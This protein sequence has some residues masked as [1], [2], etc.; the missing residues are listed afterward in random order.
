MKGIGEK[1]AIELITTYGD[2]DAIL[3][4]VE[5]ITKKRPREALLAHRDDALLSRT[6]VT[7]HC[8]APV[9]LD[10]DALAFH[11]PDVARLRQVYLDLEFASLARALGEPDAPATA[12]AE[13]DALAVE[14]TAMA[15]D[16]PR[17]SFDI[18][19][20]P[21]ANL[22]LHYTT[23]TTR[24]QLAAC[25]ARCRAV[26]SIAFDTETVLE[27]GAPGPVN[28]QRS[29]LVSISIAT[30]PGEAWYLP[31]AHVVVGAA[32]GDLLDGGELSVPRPAEG[33]L[34][35]LTGPEC[36]DFRALLEDA[37]VKKCAQNA[38]Y[39]LLVLRRA[40]VELRGLDFDPMLASYV[41][42]PGRRSHGLDALALEVFGH[43]MVSY[44]EVA[45]K[46]KQ[47]VGFDRVPLEKAAYYSCED[48]DYTLRLRRHFE[49]EVEASGMAS[50]FR[51]VEMPLVCVLEDMEWAGIKVDTGYLA[52]LKERFAGERQRVEIVNDFEERIA[53]RV[54]VVDQLLW[55][56]LMHAADAEIF[57]VHAR[58]RGTLVEHHQLLALFEAP[59]RRGERANVH[60]LRRDVEKMRENAPDL[61]IEHADQL[62]ALGYLKA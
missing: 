60:G 42:D 18:A 15:A 44:E 50:L 2:L 62:R 59:Q 48:A 20:H 10:L 47:Q 5:H 54:D 1:T 58:A 57:R 52:S 23:V 25:V 49:P 37:G 33:N 31:F 32:Q 28:A 30:A 19:E 39:D 9:D 41:L 43:R 7:I 14:P 46:G 3:A 34:P 26:G 35:P 45:G 6:L 27:E 13:G 61:G 12:V 8:D 22:P 40:G 24:E 55:E 4:N 17:L 11:A 53:P 56:I 38:K 21:L 36:A 29:N 51:D 16:D